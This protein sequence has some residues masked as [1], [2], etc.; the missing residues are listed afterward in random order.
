MNKLKF[1][2]VKNGQI[3]RRQYVVSENVYK[4]FLETFGDL[5]PV[6]V[7]DQFARKSGFKS[8]IMHGAILNGFLSH[9]IGVEFPGQYSVLQVV[10]VQYRSPVYLKDRIQLRCRV[11]HRSKAT[12]VLTLGVSW[13]RAGSGATV[14]TAKVQVGM[15]A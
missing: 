13:T 7:D 5:S 3:K 12:R 15:S 14:A 11:E 8:K 9:F 2:Q 10:N 6:H 4:R 1:S